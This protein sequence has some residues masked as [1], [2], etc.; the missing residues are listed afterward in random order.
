MVQ[1]RNFEAIVGTH[2]LDRRTSGE[3]DS[4][5][6]VD[7]CCCCLCVI[8]TCVPSHPNLR[9]V[10]CN[11]KHENGMPL[12]RCALFFGLS[13]NIL[14]GFATFENMY[15]FTHVVVSSLYEGDKRESFDL[16]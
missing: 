2:A 10:R 9:Q 3:K 7:F 11:L 16:L 8:C 13:L 4:L 14:V 15:H 12:S 1:L 5:S 6:R